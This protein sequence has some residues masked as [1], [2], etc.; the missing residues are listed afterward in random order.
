[1]QLK[2]GRCLGQY[3]FVYKHFT[4]EYHLR[5]WLLNHTTKS[6]AINITASIA[7]HLEST[8]HET[9]LCF[10]HTT[11]IHSQVQLRQAPEHNDL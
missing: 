4:L 1:M 10:I 11:Y 7:F 6:K 2:V 8:Q 9:N 5:Y 3:Q